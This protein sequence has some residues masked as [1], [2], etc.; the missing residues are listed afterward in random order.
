MEKRYPIYA[1]ADMTVDTVNG[2]I[3]LTVDKVCES[4]TDYFSLTYEQK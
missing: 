1:E 4:I 2:S 3:D